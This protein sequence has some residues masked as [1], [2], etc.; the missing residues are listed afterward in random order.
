M[1]LDPTYPSVPIFN[2]LA[3]LLVLLPLPWQ[4]HSWNI[5]TCMFSLWTA[6]C[7]F[8]IFLNTVI[9]KDN[10]NNSAPVLCDIC[11]FL[12]HQ[13]H[14][15]KVSD[16]HSTIASRFFLAFPVAIPACS[17]TI[18]RRIFKITRACK[19]VQSKREVSPTLR[20]ALY[21]D[22]LISVVRREI[23]L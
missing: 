22:R 13:S 10:T 8:I 1:A 3:F 5:G 2:F 14:F 12:S 11:K 9:W 17:L 4:L 15:S 18:N 7:C 23:S 20:R 6:A 19:L 16:L 21:P